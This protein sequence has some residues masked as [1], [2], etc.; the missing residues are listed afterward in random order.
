MVLAFLLL[1]SVAPAFAG[2]ASTGQLP[3]YPCVRCHPVF[4]DSAGKPTKPLPNGM[5]KHEI[6]LELHDI[7]GKDDK[8]CLACH[9]DPKKNPGMLIL[10]DGS[11]VD[12]SG[13]D[14]P[15]VCQRCHF[16]KYAEWK[17]GTHGKHQPKCSAAGCHDPHTPGYIFVPALPPFVGSGVQVNV[18]PRTVA[19]TPFPPP[20]AFPAPLI[21]TPSWLVVVAIVGMIAAVGI[22]VP[23]IRGKARQ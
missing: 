19:F 17:A 14:A 20:P 16:K 5:K 21:E 8:A 9:D 23:L 3:F 12:I 6:K 13:P 15:R 11:L 18:L 7:L 2:Q 4:L 1:V 10:P 22:A